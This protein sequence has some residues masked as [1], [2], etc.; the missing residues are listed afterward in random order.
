[1]VK[2]S[3]LFSGSSGNSLFI[4]DGQ[5]RLLVDVGKSSLAVERQLKEIGEEAR[6][7]S[8]IL[9]THEHIDHTR[10]LRVLAKKWNLPIYANTATVEGA[11]FEESVRRCICPIE[12]R[13]SFLLGQMEITPFCLSHDAADTMGFNI[14][15]LNEDKRL[16]IAADTGRITE[17]LIRF[18]PGSD[19][20]Y[21]ESNYDENMLFSG[22]YPYFLK[23]RIAGE[24]GHLSN[25]DCSGLCVRAVQG[26]TRH[27]VLGHL[28]RE[29]NMP[30]LAY[31]T[32]QHTL[33]QEGIT[34]GEDCT[35]EVAP[36]ETA[37]RIII[38]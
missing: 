30:E 25:K 16:T 13:V 6:Q 35:L 3:T 24:T 4:S 15:F 22:R 31:M 28:S 10:G 38:F 14:R 34:V 37:G 20:V 29:N 27:L 36:R 32:C 1:M 11:S 9:L 7:L 18:I 12:S 5:T 21:I 2:F 23:R 33:K 26:G 19:L 17:D 8:G